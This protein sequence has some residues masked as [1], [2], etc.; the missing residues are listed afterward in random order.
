MGKCDLLSSHPWFTFISPPLF[1]QQERNSDGGGTEDTD[2]GMENGQV[3][4]AVLLPDSFAVLD[5][6]Y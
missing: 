4:Y 2:D 3:E 5:S 1:A 6:S